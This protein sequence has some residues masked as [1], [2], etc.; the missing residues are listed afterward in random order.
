M[1]GVVASSSRACVSVLVV[2]VLAL[3][4]ACSSD[5]D[6]DDGGDGT[7]QS[8]D[9]IPA[10]ALELVGS[11]AEDFAVRAE[12]MGYTVRV[13]EEDGED[14]AITADAVENRLN[15]AVDSNGIVTDIKSV[16]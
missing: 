12:Q 7:E 1:E 9:E 6:G 8:D 3:G 13:V 16:G 2:A 4:A 15:V 10:D 14:L 11:D 5:D